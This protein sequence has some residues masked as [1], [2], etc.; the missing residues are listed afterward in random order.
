L[1]LPIAKSITR[2]SN[3]ARFAGNLGALLKSGLTIVEALDICAKTAPNFYYAR[4]LKQVS[5]GVIK[6]QKLSD[7]LAKHGDFFPAMAV[8]MV[9]VG[10]KSGKLEETLVYLAEFYDLEVDNATKNLSTIIEPALLILI[11]LAVGFLAL[12]IITP[13]YNITGT[14]SG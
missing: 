5:R 2:N 12:S 10:E 11:G 7:N 14:V 8:R 13:I 3:L 6:G 1:H 4:A 9:G